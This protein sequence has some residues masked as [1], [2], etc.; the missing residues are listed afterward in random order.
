MVT[1]TGG[2]GADRFIGTPQADNLR[3]G[4]GNDYLEGQGGPDRLIGDS[5]DDIIYGNAFTYDTSWWAPP[6][7]PL[8]NLI[9]SP[10]DHDTLGG[11]AGNDTLF[12]YYGNNRL[13]GGDGNDV[14]RSGY[15]RDTLIGGR[16][17]DI[18]E[19]G[20]GIDIYIPGM[21]DDV[22][23]DSNQGWTGP[24]SYAPNWGGDVIDSDVF[25]IE[26]NLGPAGHDVIHGFDFEFDII[27]IEGYTRDEVSV[28]ENRLSFSD[29]S[30]LDIVE[31]SAPEW[32]NGLIRE[33]S[34]FFFV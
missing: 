15:G 18:L 3:G 7:H 16:G 21:G 19:G 11:G 10:H 28:L 22:M 32:H 33:N 20:P 30:T 27:E 31:A 13:D 4:G 24:T 12:D 9:A 6:G 8:F 23:D 17:N 14:L 2:S 34:D 1:R 25:I 26:R 5:G 29:G